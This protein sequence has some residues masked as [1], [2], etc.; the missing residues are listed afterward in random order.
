VSQPDL[1]RIEADAIAYLRE[2]LADRAPQYLVLEGEYAE[3]PLEGEGRTYVFSFDLP[4]G[5]GIA[6]AACDTYEPKHYVVV[7]ETTPNFFPAY[8]LSADDAYSFHVG[9][10]FML[11]MELKKVG[12]EFEPPDARHLLR[13]V[14]A[15]VAPGAVVQDEKLAALFR[16]EEGYY[17]VYRLKLNEDE[18]F[19]LGADCPPGFY[20]LT[21]YPPQTAL[22]LHL[23]KLI[24][25]ER[26]A[27]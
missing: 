26:H 15:N 16:C 20:K 12:D 27:G 2:H 11:E 14:L 4:A 23:G 1:R 19:A 8:G 17:A 6:S 5:P 22:R 3:S 13:T 9:T 10:R 7:G 24:R 25:A 18:V 21:R